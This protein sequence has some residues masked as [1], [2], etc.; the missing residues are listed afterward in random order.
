MVAARLVDTILELEEIGLTGPISLKTRAK[1]EMRAADVVHNVVI[2]VILDLRA[3]AQEEV[4]VVLAQEAVVE[5]EKAEST[6][7]ADSFSRV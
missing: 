1:I 7:S 3:P 4:Q 6:I 5:K 2:L